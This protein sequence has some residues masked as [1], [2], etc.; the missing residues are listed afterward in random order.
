MTFEHRNIPGTFDDLVF[1]DSGTQ[2][3]VRPF[4]SPENARNILFHGPAGSGKSAACRVIAQGLV[5]DGHRSA[6]T[7]LNVSHLTSKNALIERLRSI[8]GYGVLSPFGRNVFIFEEVDGADSAAQKALKDE[9]DRLAPTAIFLATTNEVLKV[10]QPIRDR[11][12]EVFLPRPSP[13]AWSERASKILAN[14]GVHLSEEEVTRLLE[15]NAPAGSMRDVLRE[16]DAF[17]IAVRERKAQRAKD[18]EAVQ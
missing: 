4:A 18:R 9:L 7:T 3:S 16:L 17:A 10:I 12:L 8:V 5:G 2:A 6:V 11:F 1:Q 13:A 15:R 14:E